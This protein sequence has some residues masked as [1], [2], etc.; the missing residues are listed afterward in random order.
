REL[1]RPWLL[2]QR[3]DEKYRPTVLECETCLHARAARLRRLDDHA[4]QSHAGHHGVAHRERPSAWRRVRP[5]L[6][7]DRALAD[8]SPLKRR[9]LRRVGSPESGAYNG[10]RSAF[11]SEGG[12]M[13]GC[14]DAR[15]QAGRDREAAVHEVLRDPARDRPS[16]IG[17]LSR[18]DDR[19]GASVLTPQFARDEDE[20]RPVV[21]SA[22]ILRVVLVEDREQTHAF[23]TPLFDLAGGA[24]QVGM[25]VEQLLLRP[26][27]LLEDG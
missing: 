8:E 14:V 18:A 16:A 17:R 6:R 25:R 19:D 2:E 1:A 5:E 13:G 9:V 26:G 24:L 7:D 27:F 22:Q 21:D 12:G 4:R 3:T 23:G 20:R 15:G 11:A 10:E